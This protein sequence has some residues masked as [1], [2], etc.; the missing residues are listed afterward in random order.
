VSRDIVPTA[1]CPYLLERLG[2]IV[3]MLDDAHVE[4]TGQ[5]RLARRWPAVD[6]AG[7]L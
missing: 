7:R 5:P 3:S 1:I 2:D 6:H 4:E